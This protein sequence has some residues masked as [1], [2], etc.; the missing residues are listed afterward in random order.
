MTSKCKGPE[1][2][3]CQT[4]WQNSEKVGML[5]RNKYR[6]TLVGCGVRQNHRGSCE[7][8]RVRKEVIGGFGV[9]G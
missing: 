7:Q 9:E 4:H 8:C 5:D 6:A 3:A 1:V 2:R